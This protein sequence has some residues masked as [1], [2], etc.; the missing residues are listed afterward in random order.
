MSNLSAEDSA[1][2]TPYKLFVKQTIE[3][4]DP[5]A[6]AS[7]IAAMQR[8]VNEANQKMLENKKHVD[9]LEDQEK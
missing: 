8:N 5:V 9:L 7:M 1:W 3:K 2:F 4:C 6:Y